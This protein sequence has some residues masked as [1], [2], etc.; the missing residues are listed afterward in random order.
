MGFI[1]SKGYC[2][3]RILDKTAVCQYQ[4]GFS[5]IRFFIE[6]KNLAGKI[7]AAIRR[8]KEV[9]VRSVSYKKCVTYE[10][11]TSPSIRLA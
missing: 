3:P 7:K 6:S 2:K 10:N 5:G 11:I 1:G 8:K 9:E 4:R